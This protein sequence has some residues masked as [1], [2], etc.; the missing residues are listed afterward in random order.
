MRQHAKALA[1]RCLARVVISGAVIGSLL[2]EAVACGYHDDVSRARGVLNWVYPDAL[3]V[4]GAIANAVAERRLPAPSFAGR[5]PWGYQRT[6]RSLDQYARQLRLIA[7]R[8]QLPAFS[9]LLIEPMLWTRFV[10][11]G[12]DLQPRV[13]VPG[14]ESG[15]LVL[16]SG[17]DV[18]RE[19]ANDRLTISEAHRLG[20]F[21]LYGT[22]DQVTLFLAL[23]R[24][25]GHSD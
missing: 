13:H 18:V 7:G 16:I 17:E 21:R 20:L 15:D 19:I 8:T 5:D 14:P 10:P 12:D 6:V 2:S 22:E 25:H 9:L 11:D 23:D 4:V 24:A 1:I 3:H